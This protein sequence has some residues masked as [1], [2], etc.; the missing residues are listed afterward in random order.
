M[1]FTNSD[2]AWAY[3]K[4]DSAIVRSMV[5][6][7]TMIVTG[8]SSRGTKTVDTYSLLGFTQAHRTIGKLCGLK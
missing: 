2:S 3:D 7:K 6:G 1:L 5:S 4:E 8:F